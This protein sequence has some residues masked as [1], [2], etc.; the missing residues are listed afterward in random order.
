MP[1]S[2]AFA[3]LFGAADL[4]ISFERREITMLVG[5]RIFNKAKKAKSVTT[6]ED[7]ELAEIIREYKRAIFAKKIGS[8]G[9]EEECWQRLPYSSPSHCRRSFQP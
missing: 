6:K 1:K 8:D 2:A 4:N 5:D 9:L 7:A 3:L